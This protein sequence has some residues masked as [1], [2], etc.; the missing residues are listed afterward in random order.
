MKLPSIPN[1]GNEGKDKID[2]ALHDLANA[3]SSVR[4]YGEVLHMQAEAGKPVKPA[5]VENLLG[6]LDRAH[7]ILRTLRRETFRPGDVL[8]CLDCGH[9]FV[10]R[11]ATGRKATCRRCEG[12]NLDKWTK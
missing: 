7:D 3:L 9:E 1:V 12:E 10:H 8:R 11:K 5:T 2:G 4:S 6:E